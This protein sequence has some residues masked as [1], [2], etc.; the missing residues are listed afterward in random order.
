MEQALR[1]AMKRFALAVRRRFW[2]VTQVSAQD[3][4]PKLIALRCG[5]S[6]KLTYCGGRNCGGEG[7]VQKVETLD[8]RIPPGARTGSRVR[9]AG[10]GNAGTQ[11]GPLAGDLFI[12]MKVDAASLFRSAWR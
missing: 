7:R 4:L 6:G 2:C 11:G 1:Q 10:R 8:V 5:G 12:V 9:V 3:A